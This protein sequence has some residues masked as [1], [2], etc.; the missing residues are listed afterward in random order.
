MKKILS[1]CP[2]CSNKLEYSNLM[3]YSNVYGIKKN[4]ELTEKRIR[5]EDVGSMECGFISCSNESCDFVTDCD[6]VSENYPDIKVWQEG[7]KLYYS[8]RTEN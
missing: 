2:V 4:G 7:S 5:K 1:K 3:Q 6:L 8:V